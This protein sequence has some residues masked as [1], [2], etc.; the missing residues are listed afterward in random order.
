MPKSK[1]RKKEELDLVQSKLASSQGVVF[2]SD[3]GLTVKESQDLRKK[4][5]SEQAGYQGIKKTLLQKALA[6]AKIDAT[7]EAKG[8]V[9][10]A[11]S[12]TDAVAPARLVRAASKANE[13][14]VILGGMLEGNFIS[15]DKVLALAALPSRLELLAATVRTIQAPVSGFVNVLAGNLRGLVNVLNS[16]KDRKTA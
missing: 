7:L 1:A 5:R 2:T 6:E 13:K 11:Y 3:Q 4:L 14:L 8:N 16:V 15:K 10:V 9:A 12:D